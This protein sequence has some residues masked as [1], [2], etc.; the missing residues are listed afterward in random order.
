MVMDTLPERLRFLARSQADATFC[1]F[2]SAGREERITF[3]ELYRRSCAYAQAYRELGVREDDL[4][5]I[6]LQHSPH[7]FYSYVGAIL[8]GAVPSFM[9]FPSTK[10]RPEFYWADHK[11]LFER[12]LP[13]L[14]VTYEKNLQ[15]AEQALP[16]F[17]IPVLLASDA[18]L[19]RRDG[20]GGLAGFQR[21]AD[22]IACL[23]HS[24]GTTSLKKGV[25][26][27]HRAILEEVRSYAR[28]LDFGPDDSIAS[29]LPLYHDMGFVACFMASLLQGTHLIAMD[30]FEWVMKPP[31]LLDAIE[32]YRATFCWLPNFA[33]SHL[34]NTA[35]PS[36]QWDLSSIRA[37]INC[38]E[39]CKSHTFER[40]AE[41]F[42]ACGAG[43]EKLQVCYAMAEN[44]FGVTQT[45]I[46]GVARIARAEAEAFSTGSVKIALPGESSVAV[47]SCGKPIDGVSVEIK[48]SEGRSLEDGRIGEIYLTSPFVFE[49]YYRLPEK[50]AERLSGGWYR[51]GDMGF[52]LNGELYVTGR[53]DDM[54]IVNGRN[55]YAHEI[56]SIVNGVKYVLPGRN[57]A[58][59][60]EDALTDATGVI[61]LAECSPDADVAHLG[62]EIRR[63]VL[64]TLGLAIH[65]VFPL[66]AGQLVKTT[67]GKISRV[68]NK[69]LYV[70]GGF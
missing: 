63:R 49:G 41:R 24:S 3:G 68:K 50:T 33:F 15:S 58:I 13:R 46:G 32:K 52:M 10:Q 2:L 7:L 60:V 51:S 61:V 4:I 11:K 40:F 6:I 26:L 70:Q 39:P 20:D 44:V 43:P 59:G 53:M 64:E 16:G 14:I 56:E 54:L 12:I 22:S 62:Q 19:D 8:A 66:S 21:A 30:P 25:M 48:D 47:L 36:A 1:T 69:E 38:S 23:Q 5:I 57:V 35:K 31:I 37:F 34:V 18:I 27:T 45:P 28:A 67:S 17:S 42:G 55:Y 65:S 29:W 9:P